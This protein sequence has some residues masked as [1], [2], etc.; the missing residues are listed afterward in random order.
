MDDQ[1]LQHRFTYHPPKAEQVGIYKEI[2]KRAL[3]LARYLN[4]VMPDCREKAQALTDIEDA[5]QHANAG[6]ARHT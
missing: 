5:V 2:R 3:E 1:E 4:N 6:V